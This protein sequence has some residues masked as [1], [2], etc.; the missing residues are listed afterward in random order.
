VQRS[1][2]NRRPARH[3]EAAVTRRCELLRRYK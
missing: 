2:R 1:L 3:A